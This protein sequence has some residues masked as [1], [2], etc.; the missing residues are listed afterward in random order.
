[1]SLRV[2]QVD[3]Q[4]TMDNISGE[5]FARFA[6]LGV[7]ARTYCLSDDEQDFSQRRQE[8]Q[9]PPRKIYGQGAFSSP[10]PFE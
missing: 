8:P 9:R 10:C 4:K 1:M 3:K 5:I 7:F 2:T 6:A